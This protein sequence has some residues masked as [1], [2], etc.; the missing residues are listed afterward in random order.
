[1]LERLLELFKGESCA[2]RRGGVRRR[3]TEASAKVCE[4]CQASSPCHS[5]VCKNCLSPFAKGLGTQ[6]WLTQAAERQSA[7]MEKIDAVKYKAVSNV[8]KIVSV[9]R[10]TFQNLSLSGRFQALKVAE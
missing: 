6:K 9:G 10:Q 3:A 2:V 7:C 8:D 1:M 4:F 5:Q